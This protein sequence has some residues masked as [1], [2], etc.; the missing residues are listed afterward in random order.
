MT[1]NDALTHLHRSHRHSYNSAN[2]TSVSPVLRRRL[3][4]SPSPALSSVSIDSSSS[5]RSYSSPSYSSDSEAGVKPMRRIREPHANGSANGHANGI[6][7]VVPEETSSDEFNPITSHRL[8]STEK[9]TRPKIDWEIPRKTL[10]SLCN[11]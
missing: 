7:H 3:T 6:S 11:S 9:P 5:K 1:P 8:I 10:H 2:T 4:R